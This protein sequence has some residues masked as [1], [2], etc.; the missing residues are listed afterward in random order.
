MWGFADIGRRRDPA[1]VAGCYSV[2]VRRT[3]LPQSIGKFKGS[4]GQ[5]QEPAHLA[6]RGSCTDHREPRGRVC[7]CALPST[8]TPRRRLTSC[9]TTLPARH[10]GT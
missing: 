5:T 4:H 10:G 8:H 2:L 6:Q 3:C 7:V 9:G 1:A